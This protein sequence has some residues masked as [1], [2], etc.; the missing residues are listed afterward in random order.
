MGLGRLIDEAERVAASLDARVLSPRDAER[1]LAEATRLR[2]IAEGICVVVAPRATESGQW[3]RDGARTEAEWLGRKLGVSARDARA[4]LDTGRR[5]EELP[6]TAEAVRAGHL[7][8]EQAAAVADGAAA[9]PSSEA[10]LLELAARDSLVGLRKERDRVRA[11]AEPDPGARWRRMHRHRHLRTWTD[12]EGAGRGSWSVTP[13]CQARV[14]AALRPFADAE[15]EAARREGRHEPAEAYAVDGLVAMADA[16]NGSSLTGAASKTTK[17]PPKAIVRIDHT[18]LVRGVTAPGETCELA[19]V[20]PVPV[21]QVR[22]WMDA[23]DLF[24]TAI[25]TKGVDVCTVAHLGRK[26][27]AFQLTALQW[28]DVTC[29]VECCKRPPAEWDHHEDWA[30]THETRLWDLGGLCDHHHDLKTNK[31]YKVGEATLAG[32]IRLVPPDDG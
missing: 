1:V 4:A 16:A 15:F 25:V 14:L 24:L 9:D 32:K 29:R 2:N 18:A 22:E 6:S 30:D 17:V 27:T 31:R 26:P 19:G 10:R 28:R 7:S 12:A 11:A 8:A 23:G 3:R 21:S 13:E 5:L 20:G